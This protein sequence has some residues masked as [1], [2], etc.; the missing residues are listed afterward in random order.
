MIMAGRRRLMFAKAEE[1][2]EYLR[3]TALESG[4]FTL[5]IG[6]NVGTSYLNY[7]E[8][9]L[10]EGETWVKTNNS[11][12]TITITTPTINAGDSV[13]WRGKGMRM[14]YT[15]TSSGTKYCSTFS[16]TGQCSVSGKINTLLGLDKPDNFNIATYAY[17]RLFNAMNKLVDASE[18]VL[19]ITTT[20]CCYY[21]MFY[22]CS[23]LTKGPV[24][25]ATTLANDCYSSMFQNCTSLTTA[26]EL[27]AT[28]L[29]ANCYQNM[30]Y[31]CTSLTTAPELPATIL[32]NNCYNSMFSGCSKLTS[33][34]P[35]LATTLTYRCYYYMFENCTS[36]TIAPEIYGRLIGSDCCTGMFKGCS[37]LSS[38][39]TH[40]AS[41]GSEGNIFTDN[42]VKSV[43]SNGTFYKSLLLNIENGDSRIPNGWTVQENYDEITSFNPI[44]TFTPSGYV[45]FVHSNIIYVGLAKKFT[46]QTIYLSKNGTTWHDLQD[47]D[48]IKIE[49]N[50]NCYVCGN[51]TSNANYN[52][53]TQFAVGGAFSLSGNC[54]AIWNYSDLNANL[55][56]YCG[57]S[58]FDK[59]ISLTSIANTFLPSTNIAQYCYRYLFA[60][61]TGITTSPTLPATTLANDCYEQMFIGCINLTTA[62]TLPATT[63]TQYCYYEMF[64]NCSNLTTV[65]EEL[66]AATLAQYCYYGMF[67]GCTSLVTA[68]T[69][70]AATMLNNAYTYMF[71]DCKLLNYIKVLSLTYVYNLSFLS[72][73]SS[74]GIFVKH[75]DATWTGTTGTNGVPP[76]NWTILYFDPDTE[77]YYL[78]DKTTECDDHGNPL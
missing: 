47:T 54:N 42:W 33:I 49:Q 48:V 66:P 74:N 22:N 63:L 14:G 35:L 58:L 31:G 21:D 61:C 67:Q 72:G 45:T 29:A 12:S 64:R 43:A 24:L 7:I 15:S 28:T 51:L 13:L 10:D 68:P 41:W 75:I 4:T 8:Y 3:F 69:L 44:N 73:V 62:P 11:S 52:E 71:S 1:P 27:P 18:L 36:L 17:K 46:N 60:G 30:F 32:A 55:K 77:K 38:I 5:T 26:P 34:S 65:Q 6:S 25:P 53:F 37:S 16:S 23:S 40:F 50:E 9:S 76:N 78:D 20:S 59:C 57:R 70:P 2:V 56:S 39:K 19:P